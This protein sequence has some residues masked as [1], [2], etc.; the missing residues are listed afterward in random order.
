MGEVPH[1]GSGVCTHG[2]WLMTLFGDTAL[3]QEVNASQCDLSASCFSYSAC[4][5]PCLPTKMDLHPTGSLSPNM[6]FLLYKLLLFME[7]YHSTEI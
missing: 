6:L 4:L 1:I 5:L 2:P 7:L 3:L